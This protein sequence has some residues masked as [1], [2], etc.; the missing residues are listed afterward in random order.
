MEP[1]LRL[2]RLEWQ[3]IGQKQRRGSQMGRI[4]VYESRFLSRLWPTCKLLTLA[5]GRSIAIRKSE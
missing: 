1:R 5:I 2:C 3:V 4:G